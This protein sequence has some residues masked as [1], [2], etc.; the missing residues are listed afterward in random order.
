MATAQVNVN[1]APLA[2][3]GNLINSIREL[4]PDPVYDATGTPLPD[5]SGRIPIYILYQWLDDGLQELVQRTR[6]LVEDWY[7]SSKTNLVPFYKIDAKFVSLDA[8]F[9]NGFS[10]TYM[11]E[12]HTIYPTR[13]TTSQSLWWGYHSRTGQVSI[14]PWPVANATDPTTTLVQFGS[15]SPTDTTAQLASTTGFLPFGY[16]SIDN[17]IL[18]YGNITTAPTGLSSL[19]RGLCGSLATSHPAGAVVTHNSLW[20]HGKRAPQPMVN[21]LSPLEVPRVFI[22]PLENYVL[23]KVRDRQQLHDE[24]SL[25]LQRFEAQVDVIRANPSWRQTPYYQTMAYGQPP[26]GP[27]YFGRVIV[28]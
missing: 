11:P 5:T 12:I 3:A 7:A 6:W 16:V 2:T 22:P 20:V 19:V 9:V 17:E 18:Y 21:S 10:C 15:M 26:V 4:I 27:L 8:V 28:P 1:P 25:L 13:V 24:A 23:S 14:S